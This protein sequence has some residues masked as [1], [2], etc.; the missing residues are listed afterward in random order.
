MRFGVAGTAAVV[1]AV[2]L[3]GVPVA[4]QTS[5]VLIQ[6][7]FND[8]SFGARGWYDGA[9][10]IST[11]VKYSGAAAMECHFVI[12]ATNCAGGQWSRH[13]FTDTDSM[14]VSFYIKHSASW[15]GSGVS[16]HPHM[17]IM[18]TNLDPAY[19]GGAYTYLTG[20]IEHNGGV[21]LLAIQDG[22]NIDETR[23]GQDL[24]NVTERRAVAGCNGD[25]DGYGN[26]SCYQSG[27]VHWNSKIWSAGQVYFDSTPGS[28]RYKG[29][30]HL[31]EAYFRLNSV[32]NGIGARD[33]VLQMWYDGTPIIDRRNVVMRTGAHPTMK[34]RQFQISPYIG[35]GSP[36]DQTYWVDD[37]LIATARP[38]SPPRPPGG[39]SMLPSAPTNLRIVP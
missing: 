30:W 39:G 1:A 35:V 25:S 4:S 3:A 32:V 33:G 29:D 23:V 2:M 36:V 10:S 5:T 31:V 16:Y 20:Y 18:M 7:G 9:M 13:L 19:V 11:A 26:G 27:T 22:K 6:E 38:A 15:V 28:T 17:F 34:F 14:Y 37:L 21:P 12:G 24:T 8:T